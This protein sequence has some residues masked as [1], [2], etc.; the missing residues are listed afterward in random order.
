M[1]FVLALVVFALA[2]LYAQAVV[3]QAS[4][5][6]YCDPLRVYYPT[7][8]SCPAPWRVVNPATFA[9]QPG[10]APSPQTA[11][12]P[13][14]PVRSGEDI[15][16]E[17]SG[18][19]DQVKKASS[20]VL[21]ADRDLRQ[22]VLIRNKIFADART[23]ISPDAYKHLLAEQTQWV[24]TYSSF[25]GVPPDGPEPS[26][27]I[28]S[29]VID[30]YKRE[31]QK[32]I[33]D[34]VSRLGQQKAGYYPTWLSTDQHALVD[35]ALHQRADQERAEQER[36]QAAAA[37]QAE[38][39]KQRREQEEALAAEKAKEQLR[40]QA[41]ADRQAALA[42]KLKDLGFR[43]EKPIDF[44]LDWHDLVNSSQKVALQGRY[45]EENDVEGLVVDNLDLPLIRL[46]TD[47]TLRDARKMLLECRIK[48]SSCKIIVGAGVVSCVA[49]KD[50]LNEKE[51]PCLKVEAAFID[52]TA[53]Q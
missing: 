31:A 25:C 32:R 53:D 21:C 17:L 10:T 39:E 51:I 3:A 12:A 46:Y 38:R 1:R 27:P 37:E 44:E 24:Q 49:H 18:W 41:V 40:A 42:Q 33:A 26:Q 23:T 14:V 34:L 36:Q 35:Q 50:Q 8:P 11:P 52:P 45:V 4:P 9:P 7:V 30:C 22:M 13:T 6:Y 29:T 28:S 47:G 2:A 48:G 16:D 20:I 43:M 15:D 19:C 5:V